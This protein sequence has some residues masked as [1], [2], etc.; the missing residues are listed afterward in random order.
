MSLR[1]IIIIT[2]IRISTKLGSGEFGNVYKAV[3]S[4]SGP[5]KE[6]AVKTLK[7]DSYDQRMTEYDSYKRQ[8]SWDSSITHMLWG[9]M[10][11]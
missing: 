11:L 6:V 8:P 3:W 1:I 10:V 9:F 4:I 5:T 2:G 7:P